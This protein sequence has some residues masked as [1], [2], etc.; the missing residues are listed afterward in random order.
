MVMSAGPTPTTV[1]AILD[2]FQGM[3]NPGKELPQTSCEV[4]YF[5]TTSSPP[6]ASAFQ[7]LD[8]EKLAWK[9]QG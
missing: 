3:L 8:T 9:Q 4:A 6:I 7:H 5:L 1:L 2:L